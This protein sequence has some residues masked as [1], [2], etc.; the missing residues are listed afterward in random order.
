MRPL[1]LSAARVPRCERGKWAKRLGRH[2]GRKYGEETVRNNW[3][4]IGLATAQADYPAATRP[5]TPN[6]SPFGTD[7]F[8]SEE[9]KSRSSAVFKATQSYRISGASSLRRYRRSEKQSQCYR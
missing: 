1:V 2:I 6:I 8:I 4:R 5:L 7:P 9:A 3:M